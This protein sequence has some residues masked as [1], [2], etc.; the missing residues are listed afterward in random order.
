L[1]SIHRVYKKLKGTGIEFLLIDVME[2][3]STV[4]R[5]V[6]K[7]R[8][9]LPVLLDTDGRVAGAYQ[10]WGTPTVYLINREGNLVAAAVGQRQWGSVV[11]LRVLKSLTK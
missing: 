5:A 7:R 9:T 1:P 4:K 2:R 8:Y 3:P 10:L 6:E 11:G